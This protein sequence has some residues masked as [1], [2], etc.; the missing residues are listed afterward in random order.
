M[1]LLDAWDASNGDDRA[2]SVADRSAAVEDDELG[3]RKSDK[4]RPRSLGQRDHDDNVVEV[5]SKKSRA[6]AAVTK[7]DPSPAKALKKL[8]KA[9]PKDE[10]VVVA[11]AVD[12]QPPLHLHCKACR[13]DFGT[14]KNVWMRHMAS[15]K[16]SK[17]TNKA[18]TSGTQLTLG[19]VADYAAST[20]VVKAATAHRLRVAEVLME[21]GVP[22]SCLGNAKFRDLLEEARPQAMSLGAPSHFAQ[23]TIGPLTEKRNKDDVAW[24]SANGNMFSLFFDGYSRA[25]EHAGVIARVCS[26][27]F[28]LDERLVALKL[29]KRGLSHKGWFQVVDR[30]RRRLGGE[31]VFSVADG[32][33]SNGLV[34]DTFSSILENYAHVFCYCHAIASAASKMQCAEAATFMRNWGAVFKNSLASKDVFKARIGE[35]VLVKHKV[36]W[37]SLVPVSEQIMRKWLALKDVFK[38]IEAKGYSEA[39]V[40]TVLQALNQNPRNFDPLPLQLCAFFDAN[41]VLSRICTFL[42]GSG[43]LAPFVYPMIRTAHQ[44]FKRALGCGGPDPVFPNLCAA[45]RSVPANAPV[46]VN[47]LWGRMINT[48]RPGIDYFQSHLFLGEGSTKSRPYATG[49]ELYKFAEIFHPQYGRKLVKENGFNLN[50]FLSGTTVQSV[51]L[52]RG[53]TFVNNLKADFGLFVGVLERKVEPDKRYQADD[54]LLWW[55]E[56]G[57]QCG[58]WAAAAR[59]FALLQPSEANC[60]RA[61]AMARGTVSEQQANMLEDQL[62]LRLRL[63]YSMKPPAGID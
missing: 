33:S 18:T 53:P 50:T 58:S 59:I 8:K 42:E 25:D 28:E 20:T 13:K 34:G 54:L 12:G 5:T 27:R 60:E 49:L 30:E 1:D 44:I 39:S 22:L 9:F 63:H 2:S 47:A 43:F 55:R 36:R 32:H 15:E 16:H 3:G 7:Q 6:V 21:I 40:A 56:N 41:S 46:N 24:C 31:L 45:L 11:K 38:E 23:E 26:E 61:F 35:A 19:Q 10:F 4:A 51:L 52:S 37:F 62:E 17:R 57:A 48:L 14:R 29:F